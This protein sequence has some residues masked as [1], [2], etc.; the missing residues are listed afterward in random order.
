QRQQLAMRLLWQTHI[1]ELIEWLQKYRHQVSLPAVAD[2]RK[3]F[4]LLGQI[5]PHAIHADLSSIAQNLGWEVSE[6][7]D[8]EDILSV[9][10]NAALA[11]I[12]PENTL[13]SACLHP[14]A[15]YS[16]AEIYQTIER[17]P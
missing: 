3:C 5:P 6:S 8:T 17:K 9:K 1:L 14:K 13:I 4:E 11:F 2:L 12:Y 15:L 7:A 10:L 16:L